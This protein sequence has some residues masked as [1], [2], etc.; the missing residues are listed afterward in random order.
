MSRDDLEQKALDGVARQLLIGG[1]WRDSSRGRTFPVEDP[2][3]GTVLLEVADADADHARAALDACV[4]AQGSWAATAPR[5]RSES[6]A[7]PTS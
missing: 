6:S 2:A 7:G 4:A 5:A 3:T 1:E